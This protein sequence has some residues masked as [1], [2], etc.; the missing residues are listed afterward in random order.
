MFSLSL[1]AMPSPP[2]TTSKSS[3]A[4]AVQLPPALLSPSTT[5]AKPAAVTAGGAE[6]AAASELPGLPWKLGDNTWEGH[7][8]QAAFADGG[9]PGR[10]KTVV[11]YLPGTTCHTL[12]V[13]AIKWL[14]DRDCVVIQP[15][16]YAKTSKKKASYTAPREIKLSSC[17][18]IL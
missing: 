8:F 5:N 1:Q 17:A 15:N 2:A 3:I 6:T 16:V 10:W 11:F 14:K 12:P 18:C 9:P 4:A 7:H 13:V